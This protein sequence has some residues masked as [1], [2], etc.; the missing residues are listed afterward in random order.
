MHFSDMDLIER[1]SFRL[2][3]IWQQ[4]S[5]GQDFEFVEECLDK[6]SRIDVVAVNP[7]A[8]DCHCLLDIAPHAIERLHSVHIYPI[9][10]FI[11]YKNAKQIKWV[12]AFPLFPSKYWLSFYFLFWKWS[13]G[14]FYCNLCTWWRYQSSILALYILTVCTLQSNRAQTKACRRISVAVNRDIN[15][16]RC[17]KWTRE[18][19]FNVNLNV[20]AHRHE[21]GRR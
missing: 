7:P 21:D 5:C 2:V 4:P 19:K 10:I 17:W 3:T 1:K 16:T 20:A 9:V 12:A 15:Y 8:Q 14:V 18:N 13:G 6:W 11:R